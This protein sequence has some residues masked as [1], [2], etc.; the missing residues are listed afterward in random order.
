MGCLS[1]SQ[2]QPFS[3][4]P[5]ESVSSSGLDRKHL[6]KRNRHMN[7]VALARYA[8]VVLAASICLSFSSPVRAQSPSHLVAAKELVDI[9]GAAREFEPLVP[10]VII[11][12]A[13]QYLSSNPT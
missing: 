13:S 4:G 5:P 11:A 7:I 6:P 1:V 3:P 2:R 9:I 12:S 8:I 10:G